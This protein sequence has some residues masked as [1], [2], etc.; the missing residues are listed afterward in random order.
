MVLISLRVYSLKRSTAGAIEVRFR[1]LSRK[2]YDRG[3]ELLPP[4]SF[5]SPL[6]GF[7]FCLVRGTLGGGGED[8]RLEG[9]VGE[10]DGL[11]DFGNPE[12]EI[13]EASTDGKTRTTEW[14]EN[15]M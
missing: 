13:D 14:D 12:I 6:F 8:L 1:T 10:S 3:L 5:V 4:G 15:V 11:I 7:A 2:H 9:M